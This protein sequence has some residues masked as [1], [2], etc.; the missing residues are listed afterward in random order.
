MSKSN[1]RAVLK[2]REKKEFAK[3]HIT[4]EW[5]EVGLKPDLADSNPMLP[6]NWFSLCSG[7]QLSGQKQSSENLLV[8]VFFPFWFLKFL[9]VYSCFTVLYWVLLYSKVNHL[10][11]YT[12]P[13]FFGLSS[14]SGWLLD[15]EKPFP[16]SLSE[17][18]KSKPL[19]GT[20]SHQSEWLRSKSLQIIN[21]GEDVEKRE[22]SYTVGG[23]AN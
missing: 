14:L 16:H 2:L 18:C 5:E 17:K 9:L 15:L 6:F 10:Y 3:G 19:W 13:L 21:A 12:Y 11:G 1:F 7:L 22:P 4:C 23:N 20:I 8:I